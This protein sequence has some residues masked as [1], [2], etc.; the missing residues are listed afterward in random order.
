MHRPVIDIG[1]ISWLKRVIHSKHLLLIADKMLDR[2]D[3]SLALNALEH[4]RTANSLQNGIC[5]KSLPDASTTGLS[6]ERADYRGKS[7]VDAFAPELLAKGN[8]AGGHEF[9]VPG[10]AHCYAWWKRGD[11]LGSTNTQGAILKTKT[12][13]VKTWNRTC[14]S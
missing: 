12:V 13:D 14:I 8:A 9:F 11:V 10:S 6:T 1:R 2:C 7:D 4:E 3:D 5:T